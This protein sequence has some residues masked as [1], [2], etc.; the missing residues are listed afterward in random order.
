MSTRVIVQNNIIVT[1]EIKEMVTNLKHAI[2]TEINNSNYY[3]LLEK[4]QLNKFVEI[5]KRDISVLLE[6]RGKIRILIKRREVE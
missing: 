3:E 6:S 2:I 1:D 4:K 5:R